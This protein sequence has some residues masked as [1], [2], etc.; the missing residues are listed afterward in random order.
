[1]VKRLV[2]P[3]LFAGCVG[4]ARPD[5][6]TC[7]VDLSRACGV[8]A[9]GGVVPGSNLVGY[10]C[11]GT[12]RP[13]EDA[14]YVQGVPQ[15]RICADDGSDDAGSEGYCCTA[16]VTPCAYN[17]VAIC[18]D[19]TVGYQCRGSSRPESLNIDLSCGQGTVQGDWINYCCASTLPAPGC[20]QTDGICSARLTGWTCKGDSLPR[21]EWLGAN[22]S[23]ADS[24]YFLCPTAT[25]ANNPAYNTYCCYVAPTL[26]PGGSCVPD[27]T[28][29]GCA[30]GR[31]GFACYGYDTPPENYPP[32]RCP[33]AGFAGRSHE[34]YPATLYCCDFE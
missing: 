17:P 32:M 15:G 8:G 27:V 6:G 16:D 13:D 30:P 21:G 10:A 4:T 26:P 3:L 18:D 24:Y 25:P 22:K 34:G 29:P 31:F 2:L 7:A 5:A 28:V 12:A 23:H 1:M 33:E 14:T 11:T 20:Q 19:G 9:D